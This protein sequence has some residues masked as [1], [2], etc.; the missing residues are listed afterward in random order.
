MEWTNAPAKTWKIVNS[1]VKMDT[2]RLT[3]QRIRRIQFTY[4]QCRDTLLDGICWSLTFVVNMLYTEYI[5]NFINHNSVRAKLSSRLSFSLRLFFLYFH[6]CSLFSFNFPLLSR[7]TDAI[8]SLLHFFHDIFIIFSTPRRSIAEKYCL[9]WIGILKVWRIHRPTVL[10]AYWY[11]FQKMFRA[12]CLV[13]E[14]A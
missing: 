6:F 2:V 14:V 11:H 3:I 7:I 13:K 1:I 12:K 5:H 9:A 4:S 8:L 10:I